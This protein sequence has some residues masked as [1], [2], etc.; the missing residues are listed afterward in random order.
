MERI[1]CVK[2]GTFLAPQFVYRTTV[3]RYR[4]IPCALRSSHLSNESIALNYVGYYEQER[5]L[6]RAWTDFFV[7]GEIWG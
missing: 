3:I 5:F 6:F 4:R 2:K 1:G 7:S